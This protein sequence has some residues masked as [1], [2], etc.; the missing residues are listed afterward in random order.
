M[1]NNENILDSGEIYRDP[2]EDLPELLP[3]LELG[4]DKLG[5]VDWEPLK[6]GGTN[7]KTHKLVFPDKD[8][9]KFTGTTGAYLF[10]LVF[11]IPGLIIFLVGGIQWS[12]LTTLFGLVFAI[13]GLFIIDS[14]SIPAMFNKRIGLYWKSRQTLFSSIFTDKEAFSVNLEDIEAVQLLPEHVSS[15]DGSYYSYEINLI[16]A[17]KERLNVVDHG[18]KESALKDA[19][20]LAEFLDVPFL[21]GLDQT[22]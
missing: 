22:V 21:N 5:T 16:L 1:E 9:I 14:F 12:I 19:N 17:N 3:E 2:M 20:Y 4:P 13:S 6:G 15:S 18:H 7:F 11:L 8:S 10:G